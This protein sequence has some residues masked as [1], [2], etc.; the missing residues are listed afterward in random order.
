MP[1]YL[2]QTLG[3][4]NPPNHFANDEWYIGG[5]YV[6][7]DIK[8]RRKQVLQN[9]KRFG[10]PCLVKHRYSDLDVRNNV[11]QVSIGRDSTY[12]QPRWFDPLSLG[13]GYVSVETSPDEWVNFQTGEII[14]SI[15]NPGTNYIQAPMYRGFGPASLVYLIFLDRPRDYF[16]YDPGG[17]IYNIEQGGIIGP[18]YPKIWDGDLIIEVITDKG[19]NVQEALDYW[20]ARMITPVTMRG[21]DIRGNTDIPD[22]PSY[23]YNDYNFASNRFV[24]NQRLEANRIANLNDV[25]RQVQLDR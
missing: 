5:S 2:N 14:Q 7:W 23:T 4:N 12:G 16:A 19:G 6:P 17:A 11:A 3:I 13:T 15:N 21:R 1:I 20:E 18:W 9:L 22:N 10:T 25:R 24:M 8:R